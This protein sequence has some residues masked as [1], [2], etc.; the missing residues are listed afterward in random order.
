MVCLRRKPLNASLSLKRGAPFHRRLAFHAA[1]RLVSRRVRWLT[2]FQAG[3]IVAAG[4]FIYAPALHG[5]FL[6]DDPQY[7]T[8]NPLLR[9]PAGLWKA[10]TAPG[11]VMEFYPL[12]ETVLWLQWH[13]W[14][15]APFGYHLTNVV[16]HIVSALLLCQE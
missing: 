8:A 1:I 6:W 16:L 7:V 3:L 4:F 5:A 11:S 10:W 13:W 14:G 2:W 9:V 15:P 12:Q